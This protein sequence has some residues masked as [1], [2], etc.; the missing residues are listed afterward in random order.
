MPG[1]THVP[2]PVY[3]PPSCMAT[4]G[5]RPITQMP[6]CSVAVTSLLMVKHFG[7]LVQNEYQHVRTRRCTCRTQQDTSVCTCT[8]KHVLQHL[9]EQTRVHTH[10]GVSS[11]YLSSAPHTPVKQD[12]LMTGILL[13]LVRT[14][15]LPPTPQNHPPP[16][17]LHSGKLSH[18]PCSPMQHC[19]SNQLTP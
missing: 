7:D 19:D 15:L 6:S 10:F 17:Y 14:V 3:S 11:I 16:N 4:R 9:G 1:V 18:L 2:C 5:H 13:C 12:G 8:Q